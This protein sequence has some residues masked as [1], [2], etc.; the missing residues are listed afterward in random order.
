MGRI[1][2]YQDAEDQRYPESLPEHGLV[3]GMVGVGG[4]GMALGGG[5]GVTGNGRFCGLGTMFV[6]GV[7]H[8]FGLFQIV[9]SRRG[10]IVVVV[11]VRVMG[12]H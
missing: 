2:E 5:I 11:R 3:T 10:R 8:L 7:S 12:F 4:M 6:M 1:Q 9:V